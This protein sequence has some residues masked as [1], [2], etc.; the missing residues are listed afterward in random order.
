MVGCND[1]KS[2]PQWYGYKSENNYI[3]FHPHDGSWR[4]KAWTHDN[5][6][7]AYMWNEQ[8]I[9]DSFEAHQNTKMEV[10]K[11]L[12]KLKRASQLLKALLEK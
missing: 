8:D 6:V 7:S 5:E 10:A 9:I 12:K 4:T 11:A 3:Y 2:G 1:C